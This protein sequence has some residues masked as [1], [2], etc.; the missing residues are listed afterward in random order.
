MDKNKPQKHRKLRNSINLT[1]AVFNLGD[2]TN[3]MKLAIQ[4]QRH[5]DIIKT[6]TSAN[7]MKKRHPEIK[8]KQS[9]SNLNGKKPQEAIKI[10]TRSN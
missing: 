8:K 7:L 6:E 4:M 1:Q 5:Q 2:K 3:L 9:T 10:E